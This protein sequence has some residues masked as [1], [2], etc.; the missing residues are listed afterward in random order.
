MSDAEDPVEDFPEITRRM[1]ERAL[2][3]D[4][5]LA[6]KRREGISDIEYLQGQIAIMSGMFS[7]GITTLEI[8]L[9]KL[10]ELCGYDIQLAD[11]ET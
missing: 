8:K 6:E 5:E 7:F 10:A 9:N 3:D 1:A 4:M 2:T 11:N